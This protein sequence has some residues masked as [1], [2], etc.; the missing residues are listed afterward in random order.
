[1]I[2]LKNEIIFTLK[3]L[4][5][6]PARPVK[7]LLYWGKRNYEVSKKKGIIPLR[8]FALAFEIQL[9]VNL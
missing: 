1:M 8:W 3:Y 4:P 7:I 2:K 6:R 9:S 5:V